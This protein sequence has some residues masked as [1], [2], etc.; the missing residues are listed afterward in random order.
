MASKNR[1]RN[2]YCSPIQRRAGCVCIIG[3]N[4]RTRNENLPSIISRPHVR[5]ALSRK[6]RVAAHVGRSGLVWQVRPVRLLPCAT[7]TCLRPDQNADLNIVE[8]PSLYPQRISIIISSSIG[9]P[10][11]RP[12][13]ILECILLASAPPRLAGFSARLARHLTNTIGS[14]HAPCLFL[15]FPFLF[16]FSSGFFFWPYPCH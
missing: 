5:P 1:R 12:S 8:M 13:C 16:F 14:I 2:G 15:L 7:M 6:E 10:S 11:F 9:I 4:D 3:P